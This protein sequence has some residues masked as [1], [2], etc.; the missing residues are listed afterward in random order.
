MGSSLGKIAG[1][2]IASQPGTSPAHGQRSLLGF[3]AENSFALPKLSKRQVK[4]AS[5]AIVLQ[6]PIKKAAEL[7]DAT[8]SAVELQR[9]GASAMSLHA[10]ANLARGS[11]KVRA[12]FAKLFGF[13]EHYS[14]PDFLAAWEGFAAFYERKKREAE[15][16]PAAACD[17][18]MGDLFGPVRGN[19]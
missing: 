4:D 9:S 2:V 11:V 16:G 10:A 3:K 17:E 6:L 15:E 12:E 18:A 5:Q 7:Q 13:P 8:E 1:T 14:D 19:A